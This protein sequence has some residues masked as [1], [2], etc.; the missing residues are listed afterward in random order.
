MDS[1]LTN[2]APGVWVADGQFTNELGTVTSRMTVVRMADGRVVVHSP[3]PI[4]A[5]LRT[6]VGGLGPVAAL[7]GPN[8]FHHQFLSEWKEAFPDAK[9]FCAPGLEAK[10][11]DIRFDGILDDAGAPEWKQEIDQLLIRGVPSYSDVVFFHRAS[12]T[13]VVSDIAFNYSPAIEALDPGGADGLGPHS[14]IRAAVTDQNAF[15]DSIESVL[16][17][18]FD[19]VIVAH[20]SIVE[21]DG[22]AR[23]RK[24]F[25]F[26]IHG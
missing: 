11:S 8:V 5:K 16:R 24:G 18:H 7:I 17:W 15:R 9:L 26:L 22:H 21:T 12:R 1:V 13:L 4:D 20:G 6:A 23:F 2:L 25:A 14:R 10:R 3:V 19:R